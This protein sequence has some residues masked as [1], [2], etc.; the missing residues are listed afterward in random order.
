MLCEFGFPISIVPIVGSAAYQTSGQNLGTVPDHS[1]L[2][3]LEQVGRTSKT[4]WTDI[5]VSFRVF[6]FK[7]TVR[8]IS[9]TNLNIWAPES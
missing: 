3:R 6:F 4:G 2:A 9:G 5:K 8:V 7:V 1:K